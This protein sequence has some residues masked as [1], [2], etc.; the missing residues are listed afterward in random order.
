M[1]SQLT[2][3]EWNRISEFAETPEHLRRPELLLPSDVTD[4]D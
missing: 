1:G 2:G 4:E 3:D